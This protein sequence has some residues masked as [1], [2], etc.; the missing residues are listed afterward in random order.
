MELEDIRVEDIRDSEFVADV[1][2]GQAECRK[3][4]SG[5]KDVE[6]GQ[7]GWVVGGACAISISS[8]ST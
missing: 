1:E 3:W 8:S 4:S 2:D 5:G 6:N 7:A